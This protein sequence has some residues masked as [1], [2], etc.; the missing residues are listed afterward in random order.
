MC[1][2][3]FLRS[4]PNPTFSKGLDPDP[5][6]LRLD[7]KPCLPPAEQIYIGDAYLW[8]YNLLIIVGGAGL[9]CPIIKQG[10][11]EKYGRYY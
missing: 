1:T 10:K 11:K 6:R 7:P 5:V 8:A 9:R 4:G 3:V 2:S